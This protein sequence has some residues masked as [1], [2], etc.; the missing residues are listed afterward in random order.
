MLINQKLK[1]LN[2]KYLIYKIIFH[3]TYPSFTPLMGG[4]REAAEYILLLLFLNINQIKQE[5]I[6]NNSG[7]SMLFKQVSK[8]EFTLEYLILFIIILLNIK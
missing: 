2:I 1:N 3:I 8:Y 5:Y 6:F 4:S 7:V